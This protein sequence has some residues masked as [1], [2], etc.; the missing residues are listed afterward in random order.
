MVKLIH[1]TTLET[2]NKDAYMPWKLSFFGGREMLGQLNLG[3][4]V[5]TTLGKS[6]LYTSNVDPVLFSRKF[7]SLI[8]GG[9][10]EQHLIVA[11]SDV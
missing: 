11:R 1:F 4:S 6:A 8:R 7:S 9:I 3:R 10:F 2:E 5:D